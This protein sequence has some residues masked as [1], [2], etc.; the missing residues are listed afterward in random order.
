MREAILFFLAL[1]DICSRPG[2]KVRRQFPGQAPAQFRRQGRVG[3]GI[4]RHGFT[5]GLLT[6]SALDAGV[7]ARVDRFGNLEGFVL[8]IEGN[9]GRRYLVAPQGRTVR[10]LRALLVGGA[11]PYDGL[12]ADQG[13]PGCIVTGRLD[14]CLHLRGAVAVDIVDHLPAVGIEPG[15]CVVGKPAFNLAVDGDAIVIVKRDQFAQTQGTRQ[16]TG[17]V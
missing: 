7:P 16:G 6:G 13:G 15:R 17:L 10:A 11:L 1:L 2:S 8:P 5:P 9:T 3:L 4:G 14:S 12:A